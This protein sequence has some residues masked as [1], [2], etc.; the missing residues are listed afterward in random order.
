MLAPTGKAFYAVTVA[1]P[2]FP[3]FVL[4]II[5]G[6]I[7]MDFWFYMLINTACKAIEN[8]LLIYLGVIMGAGGNLWFYI[9]LAVIGISFITAVSIRISQYYKHKYINK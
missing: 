8:W 6:S 5:A 9:Y 4:A 2:G 3:D 7:R 1:A